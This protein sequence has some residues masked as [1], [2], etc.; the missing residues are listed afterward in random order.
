MEALHLAVSAC[1]GHGYEV[2]VQQPMYPAVAGLARMRGAR[3][4]RW[5]LM[6][7]AGAGRRGPPPPSPPFGTK[8]PAARTTTPPPPPGCPGAGGGG[9]WGR[10]PSPPRARP[11]SGKR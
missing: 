6:R 3:V 1:V 11:P 5:P 4:R 9:V 2:V 10:V 8:P 7:E